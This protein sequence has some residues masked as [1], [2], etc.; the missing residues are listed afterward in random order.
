MFHIRRYPRNNVIAVQG[1]RR[2]SFYILRRGECRALKHL[3]VCRP[4]PSS[5]RG[6]GTVKA[7]RTVI[8]EVDRLRSGDFFGEAGLFDDSAEGHGR[9]LCSVV[10]T[11]F[12]E[13]LEINLDDLKHRA[14][15]YTAADRAHAGQRDAEDGGTGSSFPLLGGGGKPSTTHG[16]E[17]D[18]GGGGADIGHVP[19]MHAGE[20]LLLVLRKHAEAKLKLLADANVLAGITRDRN[21]SAYKDGLMRDIMRDF[22]N[23]R[24]ADGLPTKASFIRE[25]AAIW[26]AQRSPAKPTPPASTQPDSGTGRRRRPCYLNK[27]RATKG[28]AATSRRARPKGN[29]EEDEQVAIGGGSTSADGGSHVWQF[30]TKR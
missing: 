28:A 30:P 26:E 17:S 23:R 13:L 1:E 4:A 3:K 18:L 16:R 5:R 6:A 29:S 21:W 15:E 7:A 10:T 19:D 22:A 2:E 24:T 27:R 11:N 8:A 20:V 12:V 14:L 9:Y 25:Q